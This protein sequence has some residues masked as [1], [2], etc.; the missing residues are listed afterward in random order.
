VFSKD[1]VPFRLRQRREAFP[2]PVKLKTGPGG[3]REHASS[4]VTLTVDQAA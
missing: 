4:D 3:R 1:G 2:V